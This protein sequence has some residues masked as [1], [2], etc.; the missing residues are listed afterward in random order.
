VVLNVTVGAA[1]EAGST[2][3]GFRV[4]GLLA[5][6]ALFQVE[7]NGTVIADDIA[8]TPY[9]KNQIFPWGGSVL[10]QNDTIIVRCYNFY[11]ADEMAVQVLC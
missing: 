8:I 1:P 3:H 4:S 7:I 11:P 6:G 2:I 10:S 5:A 9:N